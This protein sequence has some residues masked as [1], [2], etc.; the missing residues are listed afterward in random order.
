MDIFKSVAAASAEVVVMTGHGTVDYAVQALRL[1]A[2]DFL[3][4]PICMERLNAILTRVVA[5]AGGDLPG[6]PS[7]ASRPP[8]LPPC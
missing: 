1:G 4:K 5:N 2:T 8:P 6:M 7:G 3:V